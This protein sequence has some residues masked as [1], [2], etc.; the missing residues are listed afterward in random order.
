MTEPILTEGNGRPL[1]AKPEREPG[2]DVGAYLLR[3]YAWKQATTNLANDAFD[4]AF[5]KA[6]KS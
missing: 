6:M 5:R 4:D 3:L 1:P 2:E